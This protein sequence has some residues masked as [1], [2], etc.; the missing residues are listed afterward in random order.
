VPAAAV[1]ALA[2][3][4]DLVCLGADKDEDTH[5]A[6]LAAI[7]DAVTD[8]WLPEE[9]LAEAAA[10]VLAASRTVRGWHRSDAPAG[11]SLGIEAARRAL[12]V[13]RALP[14]LAGAVVLRLR[15]GSN[16]AVGDVPWGLPIGGAVLAGRAMVDVRETS[17]TADV[18]HQVGAAPV[19]ALVRGPHRY[20]WVLDLLH[21]V[22]AARPDL[23]VVEMGWPG[24]ADLPGAA[25]VR[26]YG[27]S[28][29]SGMA[30]DE[31]LG[32]HEVG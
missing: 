30:L 16:V 7:A 24:E 19:V 22:A 32:G 14:D 9:R 13:D 8:G 3:G 27:A 31:L 5:L 11:D 6:V 18:L 1:L 29:A 2:A 17:T 20:P 25:V 26:T 28:A 10:R 15:T 21:S 4:C 23:V 12:Q